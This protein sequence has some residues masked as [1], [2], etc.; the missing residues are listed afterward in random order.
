MFFGYFFKGGK[1]ELSYILNGSLAGLV[2]ITAGCAVVSPFSA[3]IIGLT[4]GVVLVISL[5][6]VEASKVDDA[7]GAFAVHGACGALGVLAIGFLGIEELVLALGG[8][9]AGLLLGGG[10]AQL[11]VQIVG[12]L[13]IAAWT[14]VTSAVMFTVL[15]AI[16]LLRMPAAADEVGIDAYEHG[17][18]V[19]P[20]VLPVPGE[21]TAPAAGD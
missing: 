1:W 14:I 3:I 8:T 19:W 11:G 15:K 20:D 13:G 2:G 12:V 9:S 5:D 4:A 6:I 18:S 21:G 17:A 16:G 10:F 7:V